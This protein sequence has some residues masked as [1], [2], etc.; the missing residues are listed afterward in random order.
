MLFSKNNHYNNRKFVEKDNNNFK[1]NRTHIMRS[2]KG[3]RQSV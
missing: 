3:E 2:T 1:K